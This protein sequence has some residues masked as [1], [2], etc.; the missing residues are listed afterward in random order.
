MNSHPDNALK[1]E[2]IYFKDVE[3]LHMDFMD[4]LKA[5]TNQKYKKRSMTWFTSLRDVDT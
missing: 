4:F 1:Q 3:S 2:L 5:A